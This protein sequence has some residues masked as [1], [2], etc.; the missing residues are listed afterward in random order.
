MFNLKKE[1]ANVSGICASV[2]NESAQFSLLGIEDANDCT[3]HVYPKH[4]E[5]V[6]QDYTTTVIGRVSAST[7]VTLCTLPCISTLEQIF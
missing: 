4:K 3:T 1:S 6:K 5:T 2:A 7:T